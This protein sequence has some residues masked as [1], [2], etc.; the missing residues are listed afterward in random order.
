MKN[1]LEQDFKCVKRLI[2]TD[3]ST[4]EIAEY[5]NRGASTVNRIRKCK[6]YEDYR[7]LINSISQKVPDE[8]TEPILIEKDKADNKCN[9]CVLNYENEI[10][11]KKL[12]TVLSILKSNGEV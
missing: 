3:L 11:R 9:S 6:T 10:L 2:D 8:K 7:K 4:A 5:T 12:N 1:I